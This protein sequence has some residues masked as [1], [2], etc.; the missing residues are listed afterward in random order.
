MYRMWPHDGRSAVPP[1]QAA[2]IL[3]GDARAHHAV[4]AT[5]FTAWRY[6]IRQRL[7]AVERAVLRRAPA[8]E[9]KQARDAE[10][11][12]SGTC[13]GA[14]HRRRVICGGP[15]ATVLP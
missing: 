3:V 15:L 6:N 14:E 13:I 4:T 1:K 8:G 5:R 12:S 7:Q 11:E 9:G 10:H 2:P